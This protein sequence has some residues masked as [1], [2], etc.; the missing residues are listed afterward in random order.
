MNDFLLATILIAVTA[1]VFMLVSVFVIHILID[2]KIFKEKEVRHFVR[3][4]IFRIKDIEN[5]NK[6]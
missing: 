5:D 3:H 2:N 6:K 1:M 4:K